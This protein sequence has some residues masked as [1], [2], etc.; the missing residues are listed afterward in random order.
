MFLLVIKT[1]S[2]PE[3]LGNNSS[4]GASKLSLVHA[5]SFVQSMVLSD[6]LVGV[7]L[8]LRNPSQRRN[9]LVSELLPVKVVVYDLH[10]LLLGLLGLLFVFLG[11]F[12]GSWLV[13]LGSSSLLGDDCS[14]E[15]VEPASPSVGNSDIPVV[16]VT[17][18]SPYSPV[19]SSPPTRSH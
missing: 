10:L 1:T 3:S 12:D 8:G 6:M 15:P 18:V 14:L 5:S 17:V 19:Q 7:A 9:L 16:S 2:L 4:S 11:D 13:D